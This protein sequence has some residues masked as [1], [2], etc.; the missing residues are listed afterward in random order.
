VVSHAAVAESLVRAVGAITGLAEA[1][2][3]VS[4]EGCDAADLAARVA[5][6]VGTGPAVIFVDLPGG[7]CLTSAVRLAQGRADLAVVTGVNLAMLLEFVF[8]R[9]LDPA[10]AARR[11]AEA[12]GR[13]IQA[14]VA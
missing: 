8:H 1:L 9:D 7:S 2:A 4:N 5:A 6:A 3:P 12:G 10:A 14:R 11:A 13:A